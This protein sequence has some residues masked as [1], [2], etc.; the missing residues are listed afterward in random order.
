[1]KHTNT[2]IRLCW[3]L[4]TVLLL[5]LAVAMLLNRSTTPDHGKTT[6]PIFPSTGASSIA[7]GTTTIS[8]TEPTVTVQTEPTVIPTQTIPATTAPNTFGI[9]LYT[10]EQL[11]DLSAKVLEYGPGRGS[12]GSRAPYAV[13]AQEKYGQYA[14]NFIAPDNGTIYLTFDCGYEYYATDENGKQYRVTERILDILQEKDVQAVFF[15]TLSYAK[16]Q[17]DLVQRMIDEGHT[18][19]NHS[20]THPIMPEQTIETMIAEVMELHNYVTEHFGYEMTL[21][22]PPTGAYSEQ[23][24]AV[25]QNLGY[26]NVH[27]SFAYADWD[28]EDQPGPVEALD[29]VTRCHHSGAIYLL[30]AVSVTNAQILSDVIDFFT[31]TGYELALFS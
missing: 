10:Y 27:W 21:F 18:V 25:V 13:Q 24:L 20:S 6:D 14:G 1:M 29:L 26:K 9:G 22:R 2:L 28:T 23:S 11:Y 3:I 31:E 17:P 5:L 15:I 8:T 7:V 30:H 12:N 4:A 19:G 16:K